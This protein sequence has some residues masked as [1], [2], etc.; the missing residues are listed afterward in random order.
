MLSQYAGAIVF[1]R[2]DADYAA[3]KPIMSNSS[4][5]VADS[6]AKPRECS[7]SLQIAFDLKNTIGPTY[8]EHTLRF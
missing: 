5:L 3:S 7:E 2:T 8:S 1:L 4:I 6:I